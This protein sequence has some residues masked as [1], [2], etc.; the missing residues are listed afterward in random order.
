VSL[1]EVFQK[2]TTF[3]THEL[4]ALGARTE[5]HLIQ[6][7]DLVLLLSCMTY[8]TAELPLHL[9]QYIAEQDYSL[10]TAIDHACWRYIM[11][12]SKDFFKNHAHPKY[13]DGLRETGVV[14]ERIPRISEMDQKLQ[15]FGWRAV[16]VTGFIPPEPFLE[17]LAHRI[18]PIAADMRK[19]ENVDYTP[20]PDIVHEAAG[21]APILADA[22]YSSYLKKFG[23]IARRVIFA[24]EDNDL[25]EAVLNLSETKE[26]PKATPEIIKKAEEQLEE[27]VKKVGYVSEAQQVTRLGWWS[28]EYG[29]FEKD[30][31]H[32][33]YGAGLLSSV[34]ESY[35]CLTEGIHKLPLT[36]DCINTSYDITKPQ[37]QLFVTNDFKKLETVIDQLAEKMA[38]RQGGQEGLQKA[39]QA[40][41]LTTTVFDSGVQISGILTN[42][43]LDEQGLPIFVK[44][45][46]PCQ[47]SSQEI[48][49]TGH[50]ADYHREGFSSPVGK[51]KGLPVTPAE[52]T[53]AQWKSI[54]CIEGL[55][56]KIE[57]ES[58]LVVHGQWFSSVRAGAKLLVMSFKN[59][60][61]RSGT[62]ILFDPS[63]GVFDMVL[64]ERV[65]SVFGGAADRNAYWQKIPQRKFKP[66]PQKS[67]LTDDNK[68][69][70]KLYAKVRE[71]RERGPMDGD[72]LGR[73]LNIHDRLEENYPGDWLLRLEILELLLAQ[74]F[75][76][77]ICSQLRNH[78]AQLATESDRM[79]ML[80]DRGLSL[81]GL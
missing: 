79:K 80:I 61:V 20:A 38:Y 54:G 2:K 67:N 17:M 22:D 62:E 76:P 23:E 35:N 39:R 10:Y 51:I 77:Q 13:L 16:I 66:R 53:V 41:T 37:P 33:I 50:G 63:W 81:L 6:K 42:Y 58:G 69:L 43:W 48:E 52:A 34:G 4:P 7:K 73:I 40:K 32:L 74:K 57:F 18:L 31:K 5:F 27:A 26:D 3:A 8:S 56:A 21:H 70:A 24:K 1:F 78:L 44:F 64:G 49:L 59:A 72:T 28:I 29:L 55:E 11:R 60:T 65:T 12:V 25:Y 47:L 75:R 19:L 71:I 68:E 36:V 9:Q 30:G 45:A 15:K 46:G 14:T